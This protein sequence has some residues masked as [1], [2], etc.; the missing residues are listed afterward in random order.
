MGRSYLLLFTKNNIVYNKM[1]MPSLICFWKPENF[2]ALSY[3]VFELEACMCNHYN[4]LAE[5]VY[6]TLFVVVY[7]CVSLLFIVIFIS[8]SIGCINRMFTNILIDGI[9]CCLQT[10]RFVYFMLL[11]VCICVLSFIDVNATMTQLQAWRYPHYNVWAEAICCCLLKTTQNECVQS[12]PF[13]KT[14]LCGKFH[15]LILFCFWVTGMYVSPFGRS[16]LMSL[17]LF[18][19]VYHYCSL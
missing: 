3:F 5:A 17:L 6:P 14:Y 9:C 8:V 15:G 10:C 11:T 16:C 7:T 19:H 2:M 12:R 13:L 18:T 4:V 1:N